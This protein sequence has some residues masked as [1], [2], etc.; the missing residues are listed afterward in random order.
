MYIMENQPQ[1]N[2]QYKHSNSDFYDE[3]EGA[4]TLNQACEITYHDTN[5]KEQKVISQIEDLYTEDGVEYVR[6]EN[7]II[8]LDNITSVNGKN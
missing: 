6:L 7:Q 1:S 2:R 4:A 3:L 8:R 5:G